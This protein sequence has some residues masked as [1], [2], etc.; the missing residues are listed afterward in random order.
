MHSVLFMNSDDVN[1]T[2]M[3]Y[4]YKGYRQ[5]RY[6]LFSYCTTERMRELRGGGALK[7]V[8]LLSGNIK[9][10]FGVD[11]HPLNLKKCLLY[12]HVDLVDLIEGM[13]WPPSPL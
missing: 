2:Y 11:Q 8:V 7:N 6:I 9:Y 12:T 4:A 3:Q 13:G 1:S 10:E 5:K